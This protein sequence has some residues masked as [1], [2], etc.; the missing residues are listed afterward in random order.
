[1]RSFTHHSQLKFS[2][3]FLNFIQIAN[4]WW[5]FFL[6][7]E[8]FIIFFLLPK[9]FWLNEKENSEIGLHYCVFLHH[10]PDKKK[11][12]NLTQMLNRKSTITLLLRFI[13]AWALTLKRG[14]SEFLEA[15]FHSSKGVFALFFWTFESNLSASCC[16]VKCNMISKARNDR[17]WFPYFC[18]S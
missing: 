1:M 5:F 7:I 6:W 15:Q 4:F 2:L 18:K 12:T 10:E 17:N 9:K 13:F 3:P 8:N 16:Q 14:F 11:Q